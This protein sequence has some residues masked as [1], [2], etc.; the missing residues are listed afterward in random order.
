MIGQTQ[1]CLVSEQSDQFY[2]GI[3]EKCDLSINI[4]RLKGDW[5]YRA[6]SKLGQST[7]YF[8]DCRC[9]FLQFTGTVSNIAFS[10]C[11]V[12]SV[13]SSLSFV[14]ATV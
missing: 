10:K 9:I 12:I 5:E 14:A 11:Q 4:Q 3:T 13:A 1:A 8:Q 6:T 7:A 2:A